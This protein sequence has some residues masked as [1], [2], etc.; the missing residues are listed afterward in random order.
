MVRLAKLRGEQ[1]MPASDA[2]RITTVDQLRARIGEPH[3]LVPHKVLKALDQLATDFIHRSP[4]V[5]LATADATGNLDVSPKGDGPGFVSVENG[6]TLLIPDRKGNKLLFGLQNILNNPHVGLIFLIP[7]TEETLRVNGTA[8]LTA[9]PTILERLSARGQPA[10]LAIRYRNAFSTAPRPS[11][12]LNSGIPRPGRSASRSRSVNSSRPRWA[13]MRRWRS[14]ST[15]LSKTI[16][17]TICDAFLQRFPV[18]KRCT[19]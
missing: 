12:A 7:G 14:K 4:F 13:G 15:N 18:A 5:L 6:T 9:D 1:R 10:L 19:Q 11:N 2:Y 8:E 16:T 17:R 3:P